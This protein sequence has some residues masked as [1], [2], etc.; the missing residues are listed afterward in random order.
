MEFPIFDTKSLS[1]GNEYNLSD[2]ADRHLYFHSKLGT[3]IED[4]KTYL[5][6]NTFVGFMLAKKSA[7][8]GTYSKMFEEIVGAD[9]FAHISVGD[10]VRDV[11]AAIENPAEMNDLRNYMKK[12]YRGFISI[13][14]AIAAL[15]NRNQSTLIPTELI[16]TLIKRE[17]EKLGRKALFI[18]GM[19]RKLDQISYSLYFRDLINFRYDPD[20]FILIDVPESLI[21]LRMKS[22]VICPLCNTSRNIR[23]LPTKFAFYSNE[24]NVFYLACDNSNCEG[25][26]KARLVGK[27]GDSAGIESIRDRLTSDG[28]LISMAGTL[29]NIPKIL[30]RN[31][32][33]VNDALGYAEPYELTPEFY[34][35]Q[36]GEKVCIK[37]RP[38]M[39]KDDEGADSNS[40]L[41]APMVV[42]LV[43]QLHK[44]LIDK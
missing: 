36:A 32:V 30:L 34:Y 18:D 31:A 1:D 4:I 35:E 44:I 38:L 2:P 37:E 12:N 5:E 43:T 41:A 28:D 21:E 8:K 20:F 9:H 27:E 15:L 3:K 6:N 14:E 10:I 24:D 25:Y 40:L 19:P 42:S 16:L 7:G 33:P 22:R 26:G 23:T 29:Q 13:D 11:H 39:F 17:I